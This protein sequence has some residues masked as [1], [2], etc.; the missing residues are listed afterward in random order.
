MRGSAFRRRR[1]RSLPR[2]GASAARST[3][4]NGIGRW[5]S[6]SPAARSPPASAI[7]TPISMASPR[8]SAAT[9]AA[10]SSPPPASN[11]SRDSLQR[12]LA[13][14]GAELLF[15]VGPRRGRALERLLDR[16]RGHQRIALAVV[17]GLADGKP[18]AAVVALG[19][20]EGFEDLSRHRGLQLSKGPPFLRG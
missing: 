3:A 9:S 18:V 19:D 1:S 4:A 14:L 5:A 17:A 15:G 8:A 11:S 7:S 12:E 16:S 2:W 20:Q 6:R 13:G 10:A